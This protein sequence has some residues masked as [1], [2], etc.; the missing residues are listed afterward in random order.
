M[1]LKRVITAFFSPTGGTK[2][3]AMALQEGFLDGIPH[4]EPEVQSYNCLTIVQRK[5]KLPTFNEHDLLV[6]CYPVFKGRLPLPL[7]TWDEL[8]GNGA[9]AV[10]VSVYGNRAIDDA[11]REAMAMLQDHGFKI[12]GHVE[13]LAEHS[14]ERSIGA[15]RPNAEDKAKLRQIA[16][17]LLKVYAASAENNTEVPLLSF[18]RTTPL[19]PM[20]PGLGVPEPQD[21]T[22]CEKCGRCA[23]ICPM[24]IIDPITQRVAPENYDKCIACLACTQA[25]RQSLRDFNPELKAAVAAKMA[26]MKEANPDP[27]PIV[28]TL[29]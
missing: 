2:K 11:G 15:G 14:L 9:H 12:V 18:D 7:Q 23:N 24:G 6:F 13:A 16:Q 20:G 22:K 25:C 27:K 3:V 8:K 4:L 10:V 19:K 28:F 17:D 21:P 29:G 5:Q 26:K 1:E